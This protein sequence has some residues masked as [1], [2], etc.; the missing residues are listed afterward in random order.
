M[1]N[2]EPIK[3]NLLVWFGTENG[4]LKRT[5]WPIKGVSMRFPGDLSAP[6]NGVSVTSQLV[7]N[8]EVDNQWESGGYGILQSLIDLNGDGQIELITVPWYDESNTYVENDTPWVVYHVD[9]SDVEPPDYLNT[10]ISHNGL[11]TDIRYDIPKDDNTLSPIPLPLWAATD[12]SYRDLVTGTNRRNTL[13]YSGGSWDAVSREFRG[14]AKVN[15]TDREKITSHYFHQ[16]SLML[17]V[18][19]SQSSKNCHIGTRNYWI[20]LPMKR[21][22]WMK[23]TDN[24][25]GRKWQSLFCMTKGSTTLL[26]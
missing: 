1:V 21:T 13:T 9:P 14:Y 7:G 16:G 8:I 22:N 20:L 4:L 3:R 23:A 11:R 25:C 18:S 12:I 10:V 15:V 6:Y 26:R 5:E 19:F 17:G 24:G 2:W